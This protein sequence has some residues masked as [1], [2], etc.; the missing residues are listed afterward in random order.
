MTVHDQDSNL[1]DVAI[2]IEDE[3]RRVDA[4]CADRNGVALVQVHFKARSLG[5]GRR[6]RGGIVSSS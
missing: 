5:R 3:H 6:E 1:W 4:S 2:A